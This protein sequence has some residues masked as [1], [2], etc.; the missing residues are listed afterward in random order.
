MRHW[1]E[2]KVLVFD[3]SF[4]HEAWND[5]EAPRVV[6]IFDIWHPDLSKGEVKLLDFL[7]KNQMRAE[8]KAVEEQRKREIQSTGTETT[9]HDD[10]FFTV[11]DRMRDA[12]VP[13]QEVWTDPSAKD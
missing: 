2:G 5:S 13:I 7:T 1:E 3:D 9:S 8:K 10:N 11:I 4:E 6:L 12:P